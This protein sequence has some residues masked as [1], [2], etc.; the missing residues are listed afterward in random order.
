MPLVLAGIALL[1]PRITVAALY[2]FTHWFTSVFSTVWWLVLGFALLPTSLLWY[3]VVCNWFDGAWG[4]IPVVGMIISL[5]IDLVSARRGR[6]L[7]A[8]A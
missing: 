6:A 5:V 7:E 1:A 3:S 2:F 8:A 4:I